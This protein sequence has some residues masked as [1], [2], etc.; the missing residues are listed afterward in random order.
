[1][2][3]NETIR[4]F[5]RP[6]STALCRLGSELSFHILNVTGNHGNR[7]AGLYMRRTPGEVRLPQHAFTRNNY[8]CVS[9]VEGFK[10][11]FHKRNEAP[12]YLYHV[13]CMINMKYCSRCRA[14]RKVHGGLWLKEEKQEDRKFRWWNITNSP[15]PPCRSRLVVCCDFGVTTRR[16]D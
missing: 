13:R 2:D 11:P 9:C 3:K 7:I 4:A 14:F 15:P 8:I 1:M 6:I 16:S 10:N 12:F 5:P